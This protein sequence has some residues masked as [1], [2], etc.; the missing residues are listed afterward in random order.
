VQQ[1]LDKPESPLGASLRIVSV[2]RAAVD[3]EGALRLPLVLG[4]EEG[5]TR[6]LVLSLRLDSIVADGAG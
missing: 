2:G 5:R 4:D 3:A 1:E 6:S